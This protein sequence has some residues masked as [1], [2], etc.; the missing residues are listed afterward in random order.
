MIGDIQE[1]ASITEVKFGVSS[2]NLAV[3]RNV[4]AQS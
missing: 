4:V 3:F 2:D 1:G